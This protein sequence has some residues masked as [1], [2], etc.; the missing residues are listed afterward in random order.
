MTIQETAP[1]EEWVS[2][3]SDGSS[4][5]TTVCMTAMRMPPNASTGTVSRSRKGVRPARLPDGS[6]IGTG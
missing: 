2:R 5:T 4:G 3:G 1:A 6:G